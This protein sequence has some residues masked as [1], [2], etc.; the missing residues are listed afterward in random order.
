VL[1]QNINGISVGNTSERLLYEVLKSVL[2]GLVLPGV[3]EFNVVGVVLKNV[4]HTV[5]SVI[6]STVHDIYQFCENNLRLDHPE[7]GE[8]AGSVRVLSAESRAES[9]NITDSA[10]EVLNRKLARDSEHGRLVEEIFLVI[11][12]LLLYGDHLLYWLFNLDFFNSLFLFLLVFLSL[13]FALLFDGFFCFKFLT[14]VLES[15]NLE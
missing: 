12:S 7:F 14:N 6:F 10:S 1:L 13:L 5:L 9:V 4:A 15:G 2:E 8:M 11:N 3:K